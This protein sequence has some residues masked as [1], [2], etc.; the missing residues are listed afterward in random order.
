[1]ENKVLTE[2]Y[3]AAPGKSY[4]IYLS[5]DMYVYEAVKLLSEIFDEISEGFFSSGDINFLCDRHTGK[6]Y[7][8]DK[9]LRQLQIKNHSSLMFV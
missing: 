8:S 6:I 4:D 2:I 1:M 3:L 9:T 5:E 7:P